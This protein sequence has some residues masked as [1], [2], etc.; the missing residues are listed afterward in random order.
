MVD[1]AQNIIQSAQDFNSFLMQQ[2][3]TFFSSLIPDMP[4]LGP[5]DKSNKD[6]L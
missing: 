2:S 1:T 6:I 4:G 3:P 5:K